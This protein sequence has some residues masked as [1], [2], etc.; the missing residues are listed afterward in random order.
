ASITKDDQEWEWL[1]KVA[2][3]A[4]PNPWRDRFR[5]PAVR[6]SREDLEQ[7]AREAK[8]EELTP[9]ALSALGNALR[10]KQAN[11]VPFLTAAQCLYPN[12]F[13]L[14]FARANALLDARRL[15]EAIRHYSVAVALQPDS[16]AA[17]NNLG[18]ALDGKGQRDEAIRE[19]R[20]AIKLDPRYAA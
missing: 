2:R 5:D 8:V 15:D 4:D 17:H 3:H 1:L 16:V 12:D 10:S 13:W 7:L 19:Y 18:N 11:A 14:N 20:A 6:R 9:Q